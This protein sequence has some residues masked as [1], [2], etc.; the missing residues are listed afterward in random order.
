MN[1]LKKKNINYLI[2]IAIC[3]LIVLSIV[4]S[5]KYGPT[6]SWV[7]IPCALIIIGGILSDI[8]INQK[9]LLVLGFWFCA[10]ISTLIFRID[11]AR[12]IGTFLIFCITYIICTGRNY[13]SNSLKLFILTYIITSTFC[14]VNIIFNYA[15]GIMYNQWQE[16]VSMIIFGVAKDPNYVTGY[17]IIPMCLLLQHFCYAKKYKVISLILF[18]IQLFA[19]FLTGS[20][21]ALV[22]IGLSAFLVVLFFILQ[23]K[24]KVVFL[25]SLL[26]ILIVGM[27][28]L[29][30][31]VPKTLLDRFFDFGS[32]GDN[33]RLRLWE[34]ALDFFSD[35]LI[36]G[37]GM[38][39]TSHYVEMLAGYHTHNVYVELLGDFGIIGLIALL[40]FVIGTFWVKKKDISFVLPIWIAGFLPMM[41]VNGF[42]T[43]LFWLPIILCSIFAR[44]SNQ[45]ENPLTEQLFEYHRSIKTEK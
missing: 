12:T 7:L 38:G 32:Y 4:N 40:V 21:G 45:T 1:S 19:C 39:S 25:V 9:S 17:M 8:Q 14:A 28:L 27:G 41:F 31:V 36:L 33:I 18:I 5:A 2:D 42:N 22:S 13:S 15:N 43:A 37:G 23:S 29:L 24:K 16:R 26:G 11:S 20:R 3:L 35:H 34:H 44:K 30:L 6:L 10:A